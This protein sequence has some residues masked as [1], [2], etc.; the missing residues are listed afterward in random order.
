MLVSCPRFRSIHSVCSGSIG[1]ADEVTSPKCPKQQNVPLSLIRI[2]KYFICLCTSC[3]EKCPDQCFL[4]SCEQT[5]YWCSSRVSEGRRP[6][7]VFFRSVPLQISVI[8]DPQEQSPRQCQ[9]RCANGLQLIQSQWLV[10]RDEP[11][12]EGGGAVMS[13][14]SVWVVQFNQWCAIFACNFPVRH[15]RHSVV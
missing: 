15:V 6:F 11:L 4:P 5:S 14:I 3:V 8:T 1:R 12:R 9:P 13:A 7:V 2:N 10:Q